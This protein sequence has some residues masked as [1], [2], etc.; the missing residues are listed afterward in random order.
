MKERL[1]AAIAAEKERRLKASQPVVLQPEFVPVI[2][3]EQVEKAQSAISH[4]PTV[5]LEELEDM[6]DFPF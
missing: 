3:A 4:L 5:S 2:K 1:A 6:V